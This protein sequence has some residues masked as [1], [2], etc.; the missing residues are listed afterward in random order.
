V[1]HP[2]E[3]L[4]EARP[5]RTLRATR[6]ETLGHLGGTAVLAAFAAIVPGDRLLAQEAT[7]MAGEGSGG[8]YTVIRIRKVKADRSGEDLTALVEAGFVPQVRELPGFVSYVVLWNAETRDWVTIGTFTD[9]AAAV[10]ST[11]V[12]A[13]F[14][15]SSGTRDYVEGDP[16]VVEG[17]VALAAADHG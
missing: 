13:A 2:I 15:E 7:P 14:G 4:K 12:A 16:I 6:R 1:D 11:S 3:A 17:A 8:R 9:Q 10:E 5:T